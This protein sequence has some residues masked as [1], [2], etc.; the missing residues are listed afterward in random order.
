MASAIAHPSRAR[1]RFDRT[2]DWLQRS[3]AAE[4]LFILSL[5]LI[6]VMY[7]TWF[8]RVTFWLF[9]LPVVLIAIARY[10]T[11]LPIVK[12]GVF[13]ASA[14]FLLLIIGSSALG[15]DTPTPMLVKYLRH[16]VAVLIFVAV[17][18]HL[19]RSNGDFL[20]L[21]FLVLAPV[22]ALV[23]ARNI[24][25][26]SGLSLQT[27][28]TVRLQGVQGLTI[29]Y[30][31][32]VIGMMFAIPCAGAVAVM[33]SRA[34]KRWQF[35]LLAVSVLILLGAIVLTGSRGSLLSATAGIG[36][37]ILL[38]ANWRLSAALVGLV[39]VAAALMLLTPL[40]GELLQRRDS[41]RLTLWPIYLDMAMLKPWLGYGLAF[42]TRR[43]LPDG[44]VVMN[45]HNIFLCAAV[46]G[47]VL[48]AMALAGIAL[49]ALVSALRAW[50]RSGEIVAL[51]LLASSLVAASVDYEIIPTDLGYLYI[52]FWLPVAICLG[53]GL[54]T[55]SRFGAKSGVAMRRG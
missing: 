54:A 15:G 35:A 48:S 17:V 31:S 30:N 37:A 42:D 21:L 11:L 46:R 39:A 52:L 22:A 53:A 3:Q 27:L 49:A 1:Q 24:V 25:S 28:L 20:R 4:K 33:A 13:I 47:G 26:F 7:S 14:A 12:S 40:P 55:E 8:A 51:S 29:Y 19:V 36:I 43:T 2:R 44:F 32:N 16:A 9:V 18:A 6:Y 10:R 5:C 38:S 41:L 23:A 50:L 45:A 34:L